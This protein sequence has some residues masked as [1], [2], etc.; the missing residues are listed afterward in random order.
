MKTKTIVFTEP[1]K[2]ELLELDV[3]VGDNHVCV[4]TAISTISCGTERANFIGDANVAG[5]AAPAVKFPRILGYCSAGTVVEVGKNVKGV[6]VGDRV[7]MY[8]SRHTKYNV[9]PESQ[10]VK[11]E[12]DSIPFEEA[13]ISYISNFPLAA[14]RKTNLEIGE[15][16]LIMGLGILGQIAVQYA[17]A[18]GACP[19]IAVDPVEE[20]RN[21]ALENGADYALDPTKEGFAET[22]KSLTGGGANTA[23][24]VTGLGIGLDQALDCMAKYGRIALLGCTRNK[25]FTID[26]YRKVHCPGITL[27]GAHNNARP[28]TES[29]HGYYTNRDEMKMHLKLYSAGRVNLHKMVKETHSPADCAE[30]YTRLANDRNFPIVVQFDWSKVED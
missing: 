10:I 11:I 12:D 25:D 23:I 9:L 27:I 22:V 1:Y 2:A 19:V 18:A 5:V 13:A 29:Y 14:I 16:C 8:G 21:I 24:E 4:K 30:I 20:R 15:S 6:A 7:A 17:R 3:P 26:Y 28:A